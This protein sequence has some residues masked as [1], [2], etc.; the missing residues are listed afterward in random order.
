MD[1]KGGDGR[2]PNL[3][4]HNDNSVKNN[5][6]WTGRNEK[7]LT[8]SKATRANIPIMAA[9]EL[10]TSAFSVKPQTETGRFGSSGGASTYKEKCGRI[11]SDAALE[12]NVDCSPQHPAR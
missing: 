2:V 10:K 11:E 1:S 7:E 4:T 12:T 9:L 3:Q 8:N 5:R 6:S